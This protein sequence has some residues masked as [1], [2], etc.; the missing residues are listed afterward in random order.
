MKNDSH[1]PAI[2]LL[3]ALVISCSAISALAAEPQKTDNAPP[4]AVKQSEEKTA[5]AKPSSKE[6][7]KPQEKKP[8]QKPTKELF[9]RFHLPLIIRLVPPEVPPEIQKPSP[10]IK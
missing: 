9:D 7:K 3:V 5:T 10:P 4:A 2:T 6:L 8:P 1:P